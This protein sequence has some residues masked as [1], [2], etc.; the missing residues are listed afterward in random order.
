MLRVVAVL[1]EVDVRVKVPKRVDQ[2]VREMR[3]SLSMPTS[4]SGS[5]RLPSK[6]SSVSGILGR[7]RR[8][9]KLRRRQ[10]LAAVARL[11]VKGTVVVAVMM[12]MAVAVDRAAA[13]LASSGPR[14]AADAISSARP[15]SAVLTPGFIVVL[16]T[17]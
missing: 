4:V 1:V 9:T 6:G 13:T 15:I 11:Q 17:G 2:I 16:M 10:M 5:L 12:L 8:R 7:T 3:G 14:A